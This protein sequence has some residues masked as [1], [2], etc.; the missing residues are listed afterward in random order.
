MFTEFLSSQ[1]PPPY[2]YNLPITPKIVPGFYGE[3][4][5]DIWGYSVYLLAEYG[6]NWDNLEF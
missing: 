6:D 2:V 5:L 4:S 1:D 3:Y